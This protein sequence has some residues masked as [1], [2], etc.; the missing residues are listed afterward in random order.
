MPHL[1]PMDATHVEAP[2]DDDMGIILNPSAQAAI[3]ID[4]MHTLGYPDVKESSKS[5]QNSRFRCENTP[6]WKCIIR[7]VMMHVKRR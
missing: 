4:G 6:L 3:P 7:V 1:R 2:F 5:S